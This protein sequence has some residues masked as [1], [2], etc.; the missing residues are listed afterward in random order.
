MLIATPILTIFF[1]IFEGSGEMWNHITQNLLPTY[2]KNSIW[3][4]LGCGIL[5]FIFGVSSAWI[6]SR[7]CV[8]FRKQFQWLLILPLAIPSYITA[9]AYAGIFDYGGII[10]RH[11]IKLNV[12]NTGGLIFVLSISL[13]PYVYLASRAFFQYQ[14]NNIIEA[15]K[16]L[17]VG[18][19]KTFFKLILPLGRPAIVGGLML[20]IMEVLND[21]GAA[22]YYGVNTFTTGIFRAWFSLEDP[23]TAIYLA[24]L[25]VV[26]IFTLL[27][28]EKWQRKNKGY[29]NAIKNHKQVARIPLKKSTKIIFFL[30]LLFP[31]FF[32][33]LL[34]VSQLFYWAFLTFSEVFTFQFITVALQSLFI[35]FLS[36]FITI[37]IALLL[38]FFTKWNRLDMLKP[39]SKIGILGYAIPGAV[40]AVG[41]LI[42]TLS[43]DKWLIVFLENNFD[44][45]TGF[46]INGTIIAL[47]YA[48]TV[49]FL[50][51][52]YNPIE[53]SSLKNGKSLSEASRLLGENNIKTF[54]KIE[55]PLLKTA[56]ISAFILVFVDVMKEL[57]LTLILKPYD[58]STLAI[59]AY[60]YAS[61]ELVAEASLPSLLI[62]V[63]GIIPIL[64]LN[65]LI[66][67]ND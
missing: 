62:V 54:F 9:Y 46:F 1:R 11:F 52:A 23:Q 58:V 26:F 63:T 35:A 7:Y 14:S 31:V 30:I 8:P 27:L 56:I 20:V 36:G 13:Y 43:V 16:L 15:S 5:T 4:V 28:I 29:F 61:D 41:I 64:F 12:M 34:P 40:I 37:F 59:K 22:K 67:K 55:F 53:A 48:Y 39:I 49:R 66:Q 2:L 3:L 18:E 45:K 17:G 60:E 25:L 6:V 51:V 21:Y 44:I 42:P 65:K 38:I 50:A 57:P 10:E 33:F 47:L 24:A 32:G 19:F